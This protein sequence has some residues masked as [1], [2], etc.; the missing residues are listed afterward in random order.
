ARQR[1]G[2]H[3]RRFL[4]RRTGGW[5]EAGR[6]EQAATLAAEL[7]GRFAR[8]RPAGVREGQAGPALAAELVLGAVFRLTGRAKHYVGPLRHAGPDCITYTKAYIARWPGCPRI[9]TGLSLD[10]GLAIRWS[11]GGLLLTRSLGR[12]FRPR[13]YAAG[14]AMSSRTSLRV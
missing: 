6:G 2:G 12:S 8:M 1:C 7:L 11:F 3:W 13:S 10:P 9:T 4:R 14:T 5:G